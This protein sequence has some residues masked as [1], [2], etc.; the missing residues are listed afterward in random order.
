[1]RENIPK[2]PEIE[3][4]FRVTTRF[5]SYIEEESIK[6]TFFT[7][8]RENG[9]VE[10]TVGE[11]FTRFIEKNASRMVGETPT[12]LGI[13]EVYV[14]RIPRCILTDI[15]N[16]R[17]FDILPK[18]DMP[19]V[20]RYLI[21]I[22]KRE[23]IKL[24][25]MDMWRPFFS[26]IRDAFPKAEIVIDTFH[27][28]R[29]A[30][31]A[32]LKDL[33]KSLNASQRR[34]LLHDRFILLKRPFNLSDHEKTILA[35]WKDKLPVLGQ[36]YAL[37]EEFLSLWRLSNRQVAENSYARWK[38]KISPRFDSSFAEILKTI[39]NWHKEIFNYFD[40]KI[41]NAFTESANNLIKFAQ[42]ES[43]RSSFEVIRAKMLCK[44]NMLYSLEVD[45]TP[46]IALSKPEG[47]R[48]ERL[49]RAREAN[50][51]ILREIRASGMSE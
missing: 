38:A 34:L 20:Y 32:Y 19:T 51:I 13:D 29:I 48:I 9:I 40:Y 30:N 50:D 3:S 18:R 47:G 43:P 23:N 14:N 25:T 39:E 27:V 21:Q 37:K 42:K 6:K 12:I 24:V 15:E 26:I 46:D 17:I 8:S 7:V 31:Q 10:N 11:I 33:R 1:M 35:I 45:S 5:L 49:Q 16:R 36:I 22:Q 41:T 2:V 4:D 44:S 28:Q